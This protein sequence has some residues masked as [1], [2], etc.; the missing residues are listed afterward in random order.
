M[1]NL[2]FIYIFL[3]PKVYS[4][5]DFTDIQKSIN[6]SKNINNISIFRK[7]NLI[8]GTL[9]NFDWKTIEPF[10]TSYVKSS[11]ENCDLIIFVY[12]ISQ[13]TITQIKS[14]GVIIYDVPEKYRYKKVI[15]FRWKIN[16]DFLISNINKYNLV[17][18]TDLRDVFFQ[19]D[20]F[21]Y[22]DGNRSFLGVALEDENLSEP[23]NK[24]WLIDAYGKD[25]YNKIKNQRI[26]CVGT[27]WGTIDKLIEFSKIMWEQLDSQWSLSLNA[28]E[29]AVANYI[30]YHDKMFNGCLIKSENKN[31]LIMTI[32]LTKEENI[33][34]DLDDNLV[35]GNGKIAAV[36]HQYDRKPKIFKKVTDKYCPDNNYEKYE[37]QIIFF[38]IFII[39]ILN[40]IILCLIFKYNSKKK[41]FNIINPSKIIKIGKNFKKNIINTDNSFFE[42]VNINYD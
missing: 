32:G 24:K 19:K 25:L 11:F 13:S 14:F 26:I 28:I 36:I 8:I 7:K 29:Q 23:I 37:K 42:K 18:S 9:T 2:L 22:Y 33:Y 16:E 21:K 39:I 27:V 34:F 40:I 31:G 6:S 10:I 3:I 17:L 12:N 4:N 41:Y 20:L 5:F 38:L 15:N 35:N 1:V 30:I